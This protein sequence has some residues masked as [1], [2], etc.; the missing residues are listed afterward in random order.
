MGRPLFLTF[1]QD[2]RPIHLNSRKRNPRRCVPWIASPLDNTDGGY[3]RLNHHTDS[4][5]IELFFDLFFVANLSTFTATREINNL[6]ALWSYIGFLSIIWFTW[7]QVSLFDIR[8]AQDS[9]F[10]RICK[11]LQLAT[12]VGFASTGSGFATQVRDEN[13]WAF[14]SLSIL[15]ACSRLLLS[16]E[17][18]IASIFLYGTMQV[19]S[20]RLLFIV[21][22]FIGTGVTYTGLYFV[23][24]NNT[25]TKGEL[26][27]QT[28]GSSGWSKWSFVHILGV[29]M[30]VYLLWQSYFDISPRMKY[31]ITNQQIWTQLHF[32]FHVMVVLLSEGSQILVLTLDI[33]LK[34]KYLSNTILS[35]CEP[36]R[37]DPNFAIDQLN[38]TIVDMDIDYTKG[39]LKE[40]RCIQYILQTL[41]DSPQ[42]CPSMN[43]PGSLT[44]QRSHD[45]MGNVTASLFS[46]MGITLPVDVVES[47]KLLMLY[48]RLLGFV[49]IYYFV[50]ASLAMFILAAFVF[51]TQ[52]HTGRIYAWV[53]ITTRVL[54]GIILLAMVTIVANFDLIYR[55][56][57]SPLIIFTFTLALF[58]ALL[59]DRLLDL[60]ALKRGKLEIEGEVSATEPYE[61]F[62]LSPMATTISDDS[63]VGS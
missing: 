47:E 62:Q 35:A 39:A 5:P 63:T 55:F 31:G 57:T 50:V 53:A 13:V 36:P 23:F 18:S 61:M 8:F 25:G 37:P 22:V 10:E 30:G 3:P 58:V 38:S 16:V 44:L 2:A 52:R 41:R 19:A 17:Y 6:E 43:N 54:L 29:T 4:T 56:M 27:N 60:I 51:L 9:I 45:L 7:F 59:I 49:Y 40:Q 12:M 21:A 32:P 46:S 1:R 15:L 34:L 28:V 14:L 48:L 20:K 11:A 26:V 24:N 33:S 42:L